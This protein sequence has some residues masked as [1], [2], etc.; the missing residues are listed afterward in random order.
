MIMVTLIQ[1]LSLTGV[2]GE[3]LGVAIDAVLDAEQ[4]VTVSDYGHLEA[5]FFPD[6]KFHVNDHKIDKF[7]IQIK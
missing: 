5:A 1:P 7:N 2:L 3:A 6:N 4:V